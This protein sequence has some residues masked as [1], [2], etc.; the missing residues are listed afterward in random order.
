[1]KFFLFVLIT[2]SLCLLVSCS[3]SSGDSASPDADNSEI[4]P[5]SEEKTSFSEIIYA[6]PDC[7]ALV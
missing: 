4:P 6:R 3:N 7:D 5:K 2:V 1:M